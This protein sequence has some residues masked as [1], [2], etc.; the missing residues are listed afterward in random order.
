M[1]SFPMEPD[2]P[3]RISPC[4]SMN[5]LYCWTYAFGNRAHRDRSTDWSVRLVCRISG[6]PSSQKSL[7]LNAYPFRI[8]IAS[9]SLPGTQVEGSSLTPRPLRHPLR[10]QRVLLEDLLWHLLT[11]QPPLV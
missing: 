3:I 1:H 7:L 2:M 10:A 5:L 8:L 11:Q 6:T 9:P 4:V